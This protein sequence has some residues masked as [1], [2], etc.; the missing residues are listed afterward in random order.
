MI[1]IIQRVTQA[2]VS[3]ANKQV[4]SIE[5]GILALVA[6]EKLDSE[7]S[8]QRLFERI[9]NYRIFPDVENRM[10]LSLNNIQGGLLLI[11]QFTLAADTNSG[12]R[13][14]FTPAATPEKGAE[15][16]NYFV[17]HAKSSYPYIQTGEFG[18]D[19][20]VSLINDDYMTFTL[21]V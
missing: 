13:P 3:I 12:N 20:Q 21:K 2:Q 15:L 5:Q 7:K 10:N 16:F 4:G 1:T 14:S 8:A 6:I 18:A 9:V 19:M 11:P 17:S